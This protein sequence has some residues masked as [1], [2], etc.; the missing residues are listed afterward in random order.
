MSN[1]LP[2]D[3]KD[4]IRKYITSV[5]LLE[6][7]FI[8]KKD[9]VKEWS[10]EDISTEMRTNT[11]YASSQLSELVNAKLIKASTH[12]G[13]YQFPE[14]SVHADLLTHLEDL[15]NSHRPSVINYIYSQPLESIRDFANAFKIKKD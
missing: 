14:Y 10:A 5:S 11:S 7:L 2:D 1:D 4:F 9:P 8:L 13:F 15:Y 12:K 3:I 6:V